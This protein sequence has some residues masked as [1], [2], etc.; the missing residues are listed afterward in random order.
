MEEMYAEQDTNEPVKDPR[1][2]DV[3][4]RARCMVKDLRNGDQIKNGGERGGW[5]L[6]WSSTEM[7]A[8]SEDSDWLTETV[9]WLVDGSETPPASCL[10]LE[11]EKEK[12]TGWKSE[13]DC[14]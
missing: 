14:P 5:G 8:N 4:I 12:Q 3:W 2:V 1:D 11:V 10:C 13:Y 6:H 9:T 7:T